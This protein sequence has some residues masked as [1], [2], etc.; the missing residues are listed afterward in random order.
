[1]LP[2][3]LSL[4]RMAASH[5]A[6]TVIPVLRCSSVIGELGFFSSLVQRTT[7]SIRP[8]SSVRALCR[9]AAA[10]NALNVDRKGKRPC[11]R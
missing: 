4:W 1:M 7:R 5:S 2:A 3:V 11:V 10:A 8:G 9:T 6:A